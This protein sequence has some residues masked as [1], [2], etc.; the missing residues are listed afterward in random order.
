[1]SDTLT[2]V[3]IIFQ[4]VL[5]VFIF[6][7]KGLKRFKETTS[8]IFFFL[9]HPSEGESVSRAPSLAGHVQLV[10]GHSTKYTVHST[11]YTGPYT[12]CRL[13][14]GSTWTAWTTTCRSPSSEPVLEIK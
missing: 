11:Q 10:T 3:L 2:T 8:L 5:T 12:A 13:T 14:L 4:K 9:A 6:F 1:M 7:F